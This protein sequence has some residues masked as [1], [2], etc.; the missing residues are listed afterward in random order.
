M[1]PTMRSSLAY[2]C[3]LSFPLL[4]TT[5][6]NMQEKTLYA[7]FL[8]LFNCVAMA[9]FFLQFPLVGRLKGVG[10]FAN[11]NWSMF[12]HRRVGK[13]LA[14]IFLLHPVLILAPRFLVS[15]DTGMQSLVA[16][17][18]ARQ[19]LTGIIAWLALLL[20]VLLAVLR[21]RLS[22]SYEVWRLTHVLGFVGI[23]A[24]ATLH[25]TTVGSHGQYETWFNGLWW[26]LFALSVGIV[27][28]NYLVKP[29]ALQAHPFTLVSVEAVSSRDWQ[30]TIE[31][32]AGADFDFE[33]GQ[34][35]WLNTD[36]A[37]AGKDHP[38]SI[39]SSRASLPRLS[40][41]IRGLG[42]FTRTLDQLQVGQQVYVDG[43]YGSI[44]LADASRASAILLIAGG[45]GIGPL[46]SMV[47][48]LAEQGDARPVRLIYGNG[49]LDQMVLQDEIATLETQMPDFRQQLVCLQ[50]CDRA[51]VYQGVIDRSVIERTMGSQAPA[52]WVVYLCGPEAMI[53]A[54]S[55]SLKE[56]GIPRRNVHYEQLSF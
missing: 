1:T 38:F 16:A 52:N 9:L 12:L 25:V 42:D 53:T 15:F 54:A 5:A 35:V 33:P 39:A 20:W 36:A 11:I 31:Q 46:L 13:W 55:G 7:S 23:A 41:L 27:A 47:R 40:F 56:I 50:A 43:P 19:L 10:V 18:Q 28:Y 22:M 24:L 2:L 29:R 17:I 49:Q 48:G 6:V 26:S 3:L 4:A 37:G 30:L 14:V 51:G 21:D 34:F 44:S 32:P 8:V 45:A